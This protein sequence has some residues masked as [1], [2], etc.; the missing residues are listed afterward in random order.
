[1]TLYLSESD[2]LNSLK[3][4]NQRAWGFEKKDWN[5]VKFSFDIAD[6][7]YIIKR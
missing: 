2:N 1:M 5:Y 3:K 7:Y 6:I 4:P